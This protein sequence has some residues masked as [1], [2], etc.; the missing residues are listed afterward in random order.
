MTFKEPVRRVDQSAITVNHAFI[1]VLLLE[2][3][4]L[5]SLLLVA[6]VALVML[7][8]AVSPDLALFQITYQDGLR[9]ARLMKAQVVIDNPEPYRF[10][11]GL[12]GMEWR[13]KENNH[14][15]GVMLTLQMGSA[16]PY[17]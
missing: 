13:Y 15:V 17:C 6:F 10:A 16:T 14:A 3:F 9:P 8:G 7:A 1:A 5:S 2:A 11:Q 12:D 4:L